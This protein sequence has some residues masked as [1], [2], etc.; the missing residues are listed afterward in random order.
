MWLMLFLLAGLG[1]VVLIVTVVLVVV[2][3]SSSPRPRRA[4]RRAVATGEG[5]GRVTASAQCPCCGAD[6]PADAPEGLCPV[7][8]LRGA[9]DSASGTQATGPYAGLTTAPTVGELARLLP[10][11]EV[12]ELLG[13]GGMGAVYKAR[14]PSLDRLVAVK[15]LPP[16][17]ANDPA[18][19]ERFQRE[20]RAL[21]RLS[22]P[23][24][25][26][27]HDVGQADGLCYFIMEYVD[28][29]NLRHLLQQ[30]LLTPAQAL[31]IVPQICDALQYAHQEGVVHR[32]IKPENILLDRKGRVKIADFGLAKLLGRDSGAF[33]LTGS[34]QAMGTVFYMA[35]EQVERPQEVDHRADIYSLGVVFYE[36]LTGELP[37]GRFALPSEKA[38]T[39]AVLD[40]VVLR[41]IERDRERRYQRA[42]EVKTAVSGVAV[43]AAPA[44]RL[45][46]AVAARVRGPA[47]ALI[48]T[49]LLEL[50]LIPVGALLAMLGWTAGFSP[51]VAFLD[52]SLLFLADVS[53]SAR[54]PTIGPG[55]S[56]MELVLF[57]LHALLGLPILLGGTAMLRL[58]AY[59]LALTA[60]VLAL[61]PIGPCCLLG[62]PTGT[63]ALATLM[64]AEVKASFERQAGSRS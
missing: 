1:A 23:H 27:V 47:I 17:A 22:H 39:D 63:W 11:L 19:L 48:V 25:V 4:V 31:A 35:P 14:Q 59:G 9:V 44:G 18:F 33:A 62:L 6:L 21:A 5:A 30:K 58:R 51:A 32:D 8:L 55:I 53:H 36:M 46:A 26:A 52:P 61:L 16:E 38:G 64:D 13:Q 15:V 42:S 43:R 12:L 2:R 40:E 50:A 20:A 34:Q 24:I 54:T 45:P 3:S 56:G 49:G 57:G 10:Q 60:A 7:C 29:V 37:V 41:A 28:G